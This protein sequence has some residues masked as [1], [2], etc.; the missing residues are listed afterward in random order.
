MNLTD[1]AASGVTVTASGSLAE[2]GG[3]GVFTFTIDPPVPF[4][5]A[6]NYT[7][8]GSATAGSDYYQLGSLTIPANQNSLFVQPSVVDD[9]TL[10]PDETLILTL[11]PGERYDVG[12]PVVAEFTIVDND[13]SLEVHLSAVSFPVVNDRKVPLIQG[14]AA[15]VSVDLARVE[16]SIQDTTTGTWLLTPANADGI[17]IWQFSDPS[18]NFQDGHRYQVYAQA[19]G[20][21]GS[22][23]RTASLSF[24]FY[25]SRQAF[26]TLFLEASSHAVL[27]NDDTLQVVGKL[28]RFPL[29]A[30]QDLSGLPLTLHITRP[31]GVVEDVELTTVTDTGQFVL[32]TAALPPLNQSGSYLFQAEFRGTHDLAPAWSD[33]FLLLVGQS[34]GYV[35]LLEGRVASREGL[36]AHNKTLNRIYRRLLERGFE[37]DNVI[38][39]NYDTSQGAVDGFP[40]LGSIQAALDDIQ[41]RMNSA[42]ASFNLIMVDHGGVDGSFYLDNDDGARLTPGALRDMLDAFEAGLQGDATEQPQNILIGAC[43]SGNFIPALSK[44][45]RLI[46][47]SAAEDEVSY[48]G[49]AEPD[50][51]RSGE[52]FMEELFQRLSAG[53][54]FKSA[55]EGATETTEH[56][57]RKGNAELSRFGDQALQHP[58]LDDNGD[59]RGSN[60]LLE[61]GDG[62]FAS[63][64]YL[65]A[66]PPL[67]T[68]YSG[69]RAKILA[70]TPTRFLSFTET[71]ADLQIWVNN[72]G[73]V[74]SAPIDVRRP[75]LVL[76]STVQAVTG[77][78]DIEG[79]QRILPLFCTNSTYPH[80]CS[81]STDV[82]HESG[83]YE[84][85]YFARDNQS[86]DIS[87]LERS[88][89]Y[90]NRKGNT[91]PHPFGLVIPHNNPN[92]LP[93]ADPNIDCPQTTLVLD[94]D[95]TADPDGE[96]LTYT[97]LLATDSEFNDIVYRAELLDVS[98][99]GIGADA[100]VTDGRTDGSRGLRD[101]TVYFWKVQ[102]IDWFGE[103]RESPVWVFR[104][105]N[106]NAPPSLVTVSVVDFVDFGPLEDGSLG[107]TGGDGGAVET[108]ELSHDFNQ[109]IATVPE[110][111]YQLSSAAPG[112]NGNTVA[113][114]LQ[115]GSHTVTMGLQSL[116]P[117]AAGDLRFAAAAATVAENAGSVA[118]MVQRKGG[119]NGAVSVNYS[120]DSGSAAAGEDYL[121]DSGTLHWGDND[122]QAKTV[123]VA[124]L[125]DGL[126][127]GEEGFSITLSNPQG[128]AGLG[129]PSTL[130][131]TV[132]D[133]EQAQNGRVQFSQ[134]LYQGAELDGQIGITVVREGGSDGAV[135]VQ[136]HTRN[137]SAQAG[138]DYV[139]TGGTLSWSHGDSAPKQFSVTLFDDRQNEPVEQF[140][141]VLNNPVGV[142]LGSRAEAS[143][144]I[145]DVGAPLP[146][147]LPAPM[148][149]FYTGVLPTVSCDTSLSTSCS[150]A[151]QVLNSPV[152]PADVWVD[153]GILSGIIQNNGM[154]SNVM[155]QPGSHISGG[156]LGGYVASISATVENVSLAE[157]A[158]LVGG[159]VAGNI[160]GS[161]NAS[162]EGVII[163]PGT[164]LDNVVIGPNVFLPDDVELGPGVRFAA[165]ITDG[166]SSGASGKISSDVSSGTPVFDT[167]ARSEMACDNPPQASCNAAGQILSNLEIPQNIWID[168]GVFS[169]SIANAGQLSNI[170]LQPGS[171]LSGGILGG[172]IASVSAMVKDVFLAE[173][174]Y[175]SGGKLGGTISG[176]GGILGS[177]QILPGSML[178]G[179][180]VSPDVSLPD[181]VELGPGVRFLDSPPPAS[182]PDYDAGVFPTKPCGESLGT[183]CSGVGQVLGNP[184]IP[185]GVWV[186]GGT[187]GGTI[188]NNGMISNVTLQPES[189]LSGSILGGIVVSDSATVEDT[190]LMKGAFLSGGKAGGRIRGNG[191]VLDN[192]QI[193]PGSV[194]RGVTL[195]HNVLLPDDVELGPGV[196]FADFASVPQDRPLQG[197]LPVLETSCSKTVGLSAYYLHA[198]ILAQGE[199]ILPQLDNLSPFYENNLQ[200][201]QKAGGM[202]FLDLEQRYAVQPAQL[203]RTSQPGGVEL[204]P[205]H[206]VRFTTATGLQLLAH[207]ALQAPCV[208]YDYMQ[209]HFGLGYRFQAD[210]NLRLDAAPGLWFSARPELSSQPVERDE[211][212]TLLQLAPSPHVPGAVFARFRFA[213]DDQVYEQRLPPAPHD[214][215][216][217]YPV[218]QNLTLDG[219]GLLRFDLDE[220]HYAGVLEYVVT[221][222]E[223]G[224]G[225]L[226][227]ENIGDANGDGIADF[228]LVYPDGARQRL[229][230]VGG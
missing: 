161:G 201:R 55:F 83:M 6:L 66:Q 42:P 167:G 133:D 79:L 141:L 212:L 11:Q 162:L 95:S 198:G 14:S 56:A 61:G 106:P 153:D 177:V 196:R 179:V 88:I 22:A 124:L 76:P 157:D 118:L 172:Y 108:D 226:H 32:G 33:E 148:P 181:G 204:L 205:G 57:T 53:V 154:V 119:K 182:Y 222:G 209:E 193:L 227:I 174:A 73:R 186:N 140:D 23:S 176:N 12:S 84:L 160:H 109:Y 100:V 113:V 101:Q 16:V 211:V 62:S 24:D 195:E 15:S 216:A 230:G 111:T 82:F 49:P 189:H 163:L 190:F 121:A 127:E 7:L 91:P 86:G 43:F 229:F 71:M 156:V 178:S 152:I 27:F 93:C 170:M 215:S 158:Y 70:V 52:L 129:S 30:G 29:V 102:A 155:L 10:D 89:V 18:L 221:Q 5:L 145:F 200:L 117:P 220:Q 47:T 191:G 58:L 39:L 192:V 25:A 225:V 96:A 185:T 9:D 112:Y 98:M 8:S 1:Y 3:D 103:I 107:I 69:E 173:D 219:Y 123:S 164:Y 17:D 105:N 213:D 19:F 210:G 110:G 171:N 187:L 165:G 87:Q 48:K 38:Y 228:V 208:L 126:Y 35:L 159:N 139:A 151:G 218:A 104:T 134:S 90:K 59:G 183:S 64:T 214:F 142:E 149:D 168:G 77:Q 207:P 20:S 85:F 203:Y 36:E 63:N 28:N 188:E 4:D 21:D 75:A 223:A 135:S 197:I 137:H 37:A 206:S 116:T 45:G 175:L 143:V 40:T 217:L 122:L 60:R 51:I 68:N 146:P 50:G 169:G 72:A 144:S 65:G 194:L 115:S 184:V 44:P 128:G 166:T 67:Q 74:N 41:A 81:G 2:G 54:S 224:D 180:T 150:G 97:L 120:V 125:D 136:Y 138:E 147:E 26:T 114:D 78:Q 92:L 199:G 46:I 94:W 34:A 99:H 132:E 131:V 13:Y 80:S 31:D 202:V 130:Q